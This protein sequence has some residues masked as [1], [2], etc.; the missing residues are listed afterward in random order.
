ML[1][2]NN[3]GKSPSGSAGE[4]KVEEKKRESGIKYS[5]PVSRKMLSCGDPVISYDSPAHKGRLRNGVDFIVPEGTP[6]KAAAEG[7]VV[8]LK[9]DS[10]RG[11]DD[12]ECDKD[13]NYIEIEHR[14]KDGRKEYS[15]YE[16]I[17]KDGSLVK[18]GDRVE[19][20]QAIGYSGATGWLGG[21]G[22]HL[23]FD[24]HTYFGEGIDDY[25]TIEIVWK[26]KS[27]QNL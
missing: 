18:V 6:I 2:E 24:V 4:T 12:E 16:H 8:E 13:G 3:S 1:Q 21:L 20:G 19:R 25:E 15:M 26:E 5:C 7:I 11:C 14:D 17:R 23:H 9:Q 10:S 27:T 22:P